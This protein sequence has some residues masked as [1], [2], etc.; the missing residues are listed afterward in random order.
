MGTDPGLTAR[1]QSVLA[2]LAQAGKRGLIA[3]SDGHNSFLASNAV[4]VLSGFRA[5]GEAAVVLDGDGGATLV[6]TP[7]WD[8][9]RAARSRMP[10]VIATNDLAAGI[11]EA[12]AAHKLL[13]ADCLGVGLSLLG[14]AQLAKIEAM[15][16]GL[17]EFS[18]G[19]LRE[20]ARVRTASE[21][22]QAR[23]AT[24]IAERGY[25]RLLEV[26][27]PGMREFELAAEIYSTMKSLGAED[28]FLLMSASQH[29]QAVRA[30]GQRVLDVGDAILAEIT[31][32]FEGQF[33]QICRTAVIGSARPVVAEKYALL[34]QAMRAGQQACVPGATVSQVTAAM[35]DVISA[36]GYGAFCK[37]PYMRVRGHGLGITSSLP[38]DIEDGNATVMEEG[39]VFVMHPNQ[40][41]PESGY[42]LCGDT[43]VVTPSGAACL[44]EQFPE[45]DIIRV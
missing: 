36:A 43:V 30:A 17:P 44:S 4:F 40:Y 7:A 42:L 29:N 39:M 34:Q 26:A 3:A 9:G 31:P 1:L 28:N 23:R 27:R 21:L 22:A 13:A 6:V 45:L 16:G 37:P 10:R 8:G 19:L 41:I 32:C 2:H 11:A 18:D 33:A 20:A 35:N 15:L 14:A 12:M 38:G 5:M 24:W 25:E